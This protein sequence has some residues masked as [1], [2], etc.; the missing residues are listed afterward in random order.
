MVE[1]QHPEERDVDAI[2]ESIVARWDETPQDGPDTGAST[3]TDESSDPTVGPPRRQSTGDVRLPPPPG[4]RGPAQS[5]GD[6]D[7]P[8]PGR[9]GR[10][11]EPELPEPVPWRTDPTNSVADALLGNDDGFLEDADDEEGFTPPP[12][13]PLPPWGDRLFWGAVVGLV[14]GPL[15]LVWLLLTRSNGF[16]STMIVIALILGG[17]ACLVLRQPT[18]RGYDPDHGARV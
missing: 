7:V 18:D 6:V 17:F 9:A 4:R 5:T 11:R 14:L 12:P 8:M 1:R 16:W 2:F 13:A 15:G 10:P 3:V